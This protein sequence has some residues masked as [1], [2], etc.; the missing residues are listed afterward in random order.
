[1]SDP[2]EFYRAMNFVDDPTSLDWIREIYLNGLLSNPATL[3]MLNPGVNAMTYASVLTVNPLLRGS[4]D[5]LLTK[6]GMQGSRTRFALEVIGS[7]KYL[8]VKSMKARRSEEFL[9]IMRTG[10]ARTDTKLAYETV[11]QPHVSAAKRAGMPKVDAALNLPGR[12]MMSVDAWF[13]IALEERFRLSHAYRQ[14]G[15]E[16]DGNAE[17]FAEL[18]EKYRLEPTEDIKTKAAQDAGR[19]MYAGKP[20]PVVRA[21]NRV[22]EEHK[23]LSMFP[24]PFLTTIAAIAKVGV[25]LT[26]GVGAF[27]NAP[28]L[29]R[30]IEAHRTVIQVVL[31]DPKKPGD[32]IIREFKGSIRPGI[33]NIEELK[34]AAKKKYPDAINMVVSAGTH[35][36]IKR[37]QHSGSVPLTDFFADQVA[38]LMITAALWWAF[39]GEDEDG[40]PYITGPRS[41]DPGKR[42]LMEARGISPWSVN[43]QAVFPAMEKPTWLDYSRLDPIAL[44]IKILATGLQFARE[45]KTAED[46]DQLLRGMVDDIS[47][48]IRD[49]TPLS[50]MFTM[51][52]SS[53]D[54]IQQ[55]FERLPS[56]L[57]PY[58]GA[59]RAIVK[60]AMKERKARDREIDATWHNTL[61]DF[62]QVTLFGI[63]PE[64]WDGVTEIN[65]L[66]EP[67]KSQRDLWQFWNPF[68]IYGEETDEVEQVMSQLDLS[69]RLPR[70]KITIG[71][72]EYKLEKDLYWQ[73]VAA[74][75]KASK[76]AA[77]KLIQRPYFKSIQSYDRKALLLNKVMQR[78]EQQVLKKLK[79]QIRREGQAG[80]GLQQ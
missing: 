79:A 10:E 55:T 32:T 2:D 51:F 52:G 19:A 5:W 56:N 9:H 70:R 44:P 18:F 34:A 66:G 33:G 72:A 71:N 16:S 74:Y 4:V 65:A 12:F 67:V 69:P 17:R 8:D 28:G 23:I 54:R 1:M 47:I 6:V 60:A 29:R 63:G 3:F 68:H 53:F 80:L 7:Q 37:E 27:Y 11:W 39:G 13:K 35:K 48:A 64:S 20:G 26:P 31:P 36:G 15:L 38:G 42:E 59:R 25:K 21:F 73:Y 22:R 46:Q 49:S 14:A 77:R 58:S 45:M 40:D 41:R 61:E 50:G 62:G 24:M 78:A 75:G 30:Y 57:F 43:L 76:E